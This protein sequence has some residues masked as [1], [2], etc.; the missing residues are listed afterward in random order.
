MVVIE[1]LLLSIW[2]VFYLVLLVRYSKPGEIAE[3]AREVGSYYDPKK[4]IFIEAFLAM[5]ITLW[6]IAVSIGGLIK[7]ISS[8][9]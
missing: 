4:L 9:R 3:Y 6:P 8:R 5:A 2:F 7:F 1:Y